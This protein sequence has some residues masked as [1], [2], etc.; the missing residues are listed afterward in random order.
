MKQ[1]GSKLDT[2]GTS[3]RKMKLAHPE[4]SEHFSHS[5]QEV[6]NVFSEDKL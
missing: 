6:L 2:T 3:L 1:Q 5:I 4:S